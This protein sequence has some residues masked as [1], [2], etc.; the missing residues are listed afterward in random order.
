MQTTDPW[1][2]YEVEV[3]CVR[4]GQTRWIPFSLRFAGQARTPQGVEPTVAARCTRCPSGSDYTKWTH[5]RRFQ[6]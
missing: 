2:I 1:D 5:K 3:R 6:Q 4:C